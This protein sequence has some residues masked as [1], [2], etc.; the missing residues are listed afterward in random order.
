MNKKE[1]EEG[2]VVIAKPGYNAEKISYNWKGW[3]NEEEKLESEKSI[4]S[5]ITNMI[6]EE[7]NGKIR[8]MGYL[9]NPINYST[10]FVNYDQ[11]D[12]ETKY[13]LALFG[14]P[15]FGTILFIGV[16]LN[17]ED[18]QITLFNSEQAD[19][20]VQFINN[21]KLFEKDAGIYKLMSETDKEEFLK[22]FIEEQT[23][24][25]DEVVDKSNSEEDIEVK[26]A[27]EELDKL[28]REDSESVF[29]AEEELKKQEEIEY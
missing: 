16:D 19:T 14:N 29:K 1:T 21:F 10:A 28:R 3:N 6:T 18:G 27:H 25:I 12:K 11:F 5:F 26:K 9:P 7:E 17:T 24:I 2:F 20:I 15:I 13:N 8:N 4:I 22:K 23:N